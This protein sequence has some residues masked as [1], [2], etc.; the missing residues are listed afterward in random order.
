ML[1]NPE[2]KRFNVFAAA[3]YSKYR[4]DDNRECPVGINFAKLIDTFVQIDD[5]DNFHLENRIP[6]DNTLGKIDIAIQ[7]QL[8]EW[9]TNK[10]F[11][12]SFEN[13]RATSLTKKY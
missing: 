13:P 5:K 12:A 9:K 7:K 11:A 10:L 6:D 1:T 4:L 3:L 2:L 8:T